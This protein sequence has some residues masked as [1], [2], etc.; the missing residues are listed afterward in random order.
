MLLYIF[1]NSR[2]VRKNQFEGTAHRR[3]KM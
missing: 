1:K 3:E 2:S